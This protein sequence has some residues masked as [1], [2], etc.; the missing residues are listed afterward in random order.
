[1]I[2]AIT[3]GLFNAPSPA[4][5]VLSADILVVAGGGGGGSYRG[6]GGG[7]GGLLGFASQSLTIGNLFTIS[8]GSGGAGGVDSGGYAVGNVGANG[9]DSQFGT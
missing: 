9:L 7:A 4:P 8:V 2:G 1:M 5:T 3:A 6:A